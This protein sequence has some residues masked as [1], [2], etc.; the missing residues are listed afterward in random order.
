MRDFIICIFFVELYIDTKKQ[1]YKDLGFKR[2]VPYS[3]L[4]Q[5]ALDV[6]LEYQF[7]IMKY[8]V[9]S[10][11]VYLASWKFDVIFQDTITPP[12]HRNFYSSDI[13]PIV[14]L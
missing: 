11:H 1:C 13:F 4:L 7:V 12:V 2:C 10:M 9:P 5:C 14:C 3:C 6:R 8:M